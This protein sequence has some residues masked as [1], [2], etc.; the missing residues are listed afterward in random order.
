MSI[1][2][3]QSIFQDSIMPYQHLIQMFVVNRCCKSRYFEDIWNLGIFRLMTFSK[4]SIIC[5]EIMNLECLNTC[6]FF[7]TFKLN[8]WRHVYKMFEE[9]FMGCYSS[10]YAASQAGK[11]LKQ[12]LLLGNNK[13]KHLPLSFCK[14]GHKI[15]I[16]TDFHEW[17]SLHISWAWIGQNYQP[18]IDSRC[19]TRGGGH[20]LISS[21]FRCIKN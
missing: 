10:K 4:H 9:H 18:Y 7:K 8:V 13:E 16:N 6:F 5:L 21:W 2:D 14:H 3:S 1:E 17:W 15:T 11:V 19:A 12:I 20:F